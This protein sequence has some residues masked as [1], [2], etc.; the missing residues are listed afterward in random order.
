[1]S[2]ELEWDVAEAPDGRPLGDVPDLALNEPSTAAPEPRPTPQA[3]RP[4]QPVPRA[5]TP[6][7]PWIRPVLL[8]LALAVVSAV[9][10]RSITRLGWQ[11]VTGDIEAMVRYEDQQA[12]AGRADLVLSVQDSGNG[13]WLETRRA[14][15]ARELPAPLP[16]PMLQPAGAAVAVDGVSTLDAGYVTATARRAYLTPDGQ[17]LSF[18][19]P[20]IYQREGP[21][22]WQHTAPPGEYWG[23]WTDWR[24]D[25]LHI[26]HSERD[27][28]LVAAVAPR[29]DAWLRQACGTWSTPCAGALPAKLYLDSYVGSLE[30]NPLAN[31]EVRV[32]FGEGPGALP[33]DYFV[34]VPSPQ[35]AGIPAGPAG[36]TFLAQYLAVRM[37]ASLAARAAP[38]QP[39]ASRLAASAIMALN[40]T[41]AD[42]GFA[43]LD[44][45][46]EPVAASA[47]PSDDDPSAKMSILLD[48]AGSP[49]VTLAWIEYQIQPGDTLLA[50]A[51]EH[52]VAVEAIV[53]WN[54]LPNPDLIVA[55]TTIM[56]PIDQRRLGLLP[57]AGASAT[58]AAPTP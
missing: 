22:D 36:E 19:L 14:Q 2:I 39:E 41:R 57:G 50:V 33:A 47:G 54:D 34:S 27:A 49:P 55:G 25:F 31:V 42:P 16:V 44:P 9:S 40:L 58:P 11:R 7:R 20:Q 13:D 48:Q 4:P 35:I 52:D 6:R 12:Y 56:I 53:Q 46:S 15:L 43:A 29:L 32:E 26:R 1:M 3:A 51:I 23:A 24:T 45:G 28:A 38:S 8:G 5:Q 10:V 17:Q 21:D 30:Y 37:I 18:V